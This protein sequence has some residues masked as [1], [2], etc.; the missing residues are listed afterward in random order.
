M[1]SIFSLLNRLGSE[2][3]DLKRQI[4][5]SLYQNPFLNTE[6]EALS[7]RFA[8]PPGVVSR[9]LDDL[10][11]RE[12]LVQT[13][14][15]GLGLSPSPD[16]Y[17]HV[18]TLAKEC[19]VEENSLRKQIY[20]LET[21]ERLKQKL[22]VSKQEVEAI[23]DIVPAGVMIFDRNGSLLKSSR[24]A[25]DIL[26]LKE[27]QMREK[28]IWEALGV[29]K[30][31][32]EG[33]SDQTLPELLGETKERRWELEQD[34][35]VEIVARPFS[36]GPEGKGIILT[37]RDISARR[38]AEEA[39]A[40]LREDF[41]SMIRHELVKPLIGIERALGSFGGTVLMDE[42]ERDGLFDNARVGL[43]RIKSMIDDMLLLARLERDPM[44]VSPGD[45]I[46]L[47]LLLTSAELTF[48]ERAAEGGLCLKSEVPDDDVEFM[49][50]ENRIMQVLDNLMDNAIKFTPPGGSIVLT[51]KRNP[52]GEW[53]EISVSDTGIGI[54]PSEKDRIFT[55]FYQVEQGPDRQ[56]GLGLGL[57]ICQGIVSSHGGRIEL[58]S[59]ADSGT[60]VTVLLPGDQNKRKSGVKS[61]NS[62]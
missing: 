38:A 27:A 8:H 11:G 48:R 10:C 59:G 24:A 36:L 39:A 45:T 26:G 57:A 49:G 22:A 53:V 15:G 14:W 42:S 17:G 58:E 47:T 28:G 62:G 2:Q 41:F 61:R 1:S 31:G 20:E 19:G 34:P 29:S 46:L 51:G 55:K 25:W 21:T 60:T 9:I 44:A 33:A 18:V 52:G 3:I 7:L 35:P 23:L 37:L 40:R 32:F 30:K 12:I 50:D 16:I 54:H 6:I 56:E 5:L 13:G 4:V 43:K